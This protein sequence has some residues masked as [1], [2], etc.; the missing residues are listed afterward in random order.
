MKS[1]PD[2]NSTTAREAFIEA[3]VRRA[4]SVGFEI[5]A[6]EDGCIYAHDPEDDFGPLKMFAAPCDCGCTEG[7]GMFEKE[8]LRERNTDV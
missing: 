6:T 2:P 8:E 7:W 4:R 3:Y 5:K 1:A